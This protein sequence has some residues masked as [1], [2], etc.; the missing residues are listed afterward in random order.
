MKG[1]D[2]PQKNN[3]LGKPESMTDDQCYALPV[4]HYTSNEGFPNVLSCWE[5]TDEDIDNIIKHRKLWS[6]QVGTTVQPFSIFTEDPFANCGGSWNHI[7]EMGRQML[8]GDTPTLVGWEF[9]IPEADHL[10][11]CLQYAARQ[12]D[13][14]QSELLMQYAVEQVIRHTPG[15][16]KPKLPT[17]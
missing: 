3:V 9:S 8:K 12:V 2:F 13:V 14:E 15:L 6:N 11:K 1:I 4:H 17:Q 10:V 7:F 16:H 5:L